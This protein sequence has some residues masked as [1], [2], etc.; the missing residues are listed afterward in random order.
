MGRQYNLHHKSQPFWA[1][2]CTYPGRFS[3]AVIN[4]K[5]YLQVPLCPEC[6]RKRR[7]RDL[8]IWC[9]LGNSVRTAGHRATSGMN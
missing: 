1:T 2:K 7:H 9:V 5:Q 3:C 8:A 4:R 6:S